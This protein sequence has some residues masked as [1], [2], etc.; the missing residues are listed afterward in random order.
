MRY[1]VLVLG[2]S[3]MPWGCGSGDSAPTRADH[4]ALLQ[5]LDAMDR[6]LDALEQARD[7]AEAE[8]SEADPLRPV[9][10]IAPL[11]PDD[12]PPVAATLRVELHPLGLRIEGED[13]THAQARARFERTAAE[14]PET[15]LVV[16]AEPGVPHRAVV[17]LLDLAREAGLEQIAMS[18]RVHEP[19]LGTPELDAP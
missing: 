9:P 13:V 16:L 2:L 8:P 19:E 10:R 11:L 5:R 12:A 6:R 18:A 7:R 14:Q 17:E 15:R 4:E 3:I 1:R